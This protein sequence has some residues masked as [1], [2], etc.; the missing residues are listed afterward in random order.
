MTQAAVDYVAAA[1]LVRLELVLHTVAE[2]CLNWEQVT[3]SSYVSNELHL[4]DSDG[5]S[6]GTQAESVVSH[7][8]SVTGSIPPPVCGSGEPG[9]R[10][11]GDSEFREENCF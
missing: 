5:Q 6:D 4:T 7:V 11:T 10:P 1:L 8:F 3:S 9:L 2:C